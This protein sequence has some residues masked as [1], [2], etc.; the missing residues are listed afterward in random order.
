MSIN[1]TSPPRPFN[2]RIFQF[3]ILATIP[4]DQKNF[5][6]DCKD[7]LSCAERSH[8]KASG[9]LSSPN[10]IRKETKR[11]KNKRACEEEESR[12]MN[13][14]TLSW[15]NFGCRLLQTLPGRLFENALAEQNT[16]LSLSLSLPFLYFVA[17]RKFPFFFC[18]DFQTT[19]VF[20]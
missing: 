9:K 7:F 12:I 13:Q 8:R 11:F 19:T 14:E 10:K 17:I 3:S 15:A 2:L 1:S 20:Q 16:N 5:C 6:R 4:V 18:L